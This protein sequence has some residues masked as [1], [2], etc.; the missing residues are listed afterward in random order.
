MNHKE[1]TIIDVFEAVNTLAGKVNDVAG[2]VNVLSGTIN[3]VLEAVNDF[4]G[5]VDQRFDNVEGRLDNVEAKMITKN[6]LDY[7]FGE[8]KG[9]MV[10]LMRKEDRKLMTLAET[11]HGTKM[12]SGSKMKQLRR[13]PPF[14]KTI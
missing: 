3:D 8:L 7:K 2:T 1:P 14:P 13:L 11:L 6:Y 4:A 9:E 5:K 10:L 12:I